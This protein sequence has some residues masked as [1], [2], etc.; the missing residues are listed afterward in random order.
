MLSLLKRNSGFTLIELM[1]VVAII[2]I[3]AA[4]ALPSYLE[5]V[6]KSRRGE[7]KAE[8]TTLVHQL[9]RC[10]TRFNSYA[11]DD[12]GVG[13]GDEFETSS[14]QHEIS[15]AATAL[16]Y[17]ISAVPQ[18]T[19]TRCGTLEINNAGIKSSADNDYCW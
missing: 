13:D 2:G 4:I 12:C 16:E 10:L 18:Y 3:I 11:D 1:V 5:S 9:E 8:M 6:N 15:I 14:G 17:T 19:D 7:A